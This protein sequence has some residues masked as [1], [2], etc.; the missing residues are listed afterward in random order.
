VSV[1]SATSRKSL[2]NIILQVYYLQAVTNY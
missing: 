1:L 2:V